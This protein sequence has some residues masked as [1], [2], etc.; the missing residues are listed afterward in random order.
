MTESQAFIL[1]W[2]C[3]APGGQLYV[4]GHTTYPDFVEVSRGVTGMRDPKKGE[5]LR[6][7]TRK[8]ERLVDRGWLTVRKECFYTITDDGREALKSRKG[9]L[10]IRRLVDRYVADQGR[11]QLECPECGEVL[12]DKRG[13][14]HRCYGGFGDPSEAPSEGEI[15]GDVGDK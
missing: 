6:T 13:T 11:R 4:S 9:E 14:G 5:D 12:V 7:L 3:E 1:L 10:A 8:L 15:L 2:A